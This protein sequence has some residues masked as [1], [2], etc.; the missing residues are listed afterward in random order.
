MYDEMGGAKLNG[1]RGGRADPP[2]IPKAADT[3]ASWSPEQRINSHWWGGG[4]NPAKHT[5]KGHTQRREIGVSPRD[6][7]HGSVPNFE[8]D[9]PRTLFHNKNNNIRK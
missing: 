1:E 8:R 3:S 5:A 9:P 4:G 7:R 6:A 2:F